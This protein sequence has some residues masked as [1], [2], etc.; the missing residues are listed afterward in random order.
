MDRNSMVDSEISHDEQDLFRVEK[1]K[2][3]TT[4]KNGNL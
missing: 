3:D 1:I 2:S 4:R